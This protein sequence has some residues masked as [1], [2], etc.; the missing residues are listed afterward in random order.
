MG[1]DIYLST[2]FLSV[3]L[4][5]S[6]VYMMF[7]TKDKSNI[8]K[9]IIAILILS[10]SKAFID[11]STSGLENCMTFF[12][13]A[14]FY[15]RFFNEKIKTYES[16][17]FLYLCIIAS[18]M[19]IN[20]LDA[21]LLFLPALCYSLFV[22]FNLKKILIGLVGFLPFIAWEAFSFVYFGFLFPN[23]A[24]SKLNVG[25]GLFSKIK[26]GI[27]YMLSGFTF[28]DYITL[29]III[30]AVILCIIKRDKKQ[31]IA[32]VGVSIYMLY[33]LCIGG[34][35]MSGRFLS[36]PL[37]LSVV[38]IVFSIK[39]LSKKKLIAVCLSIIIIGSIS[40]QS[41][42][43]SNIQYSRINS[44]TTNYALIADER[45]VYYFESGLSW[46]LKRAIKNGYD[47]NIPVSK[48]GDA[49][50]IADKNEIQV[51]HTIGFY[52]YYADNET[53][54]VDPL[55]LADALL[56]RVKPTVIQ[57]PG[58]YVRELPHGY[59]EGLQSRTNKIEDESLHIYY[60]KLK[61]I[62]SGPIF[63]RNRILTA[64]YMNLGKYDYLIEE[65]EERVGIK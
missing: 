4:T 9:V 11:Y 53:Y 41:P 14:L 31:L 16:K 18:L 47:K 65:Y 48:Y 1:K 59:L 15:R 33:I 12:I 6:A 34:D 42:V 10:F 37:F 61:Y 52:G 25:I 30:F 54:I 17:E 8:S 45:K 62:I 57:R 55:A 29:P 40:I 23:T 26:T 64:I 36:A 46:V 49:G 2:M 19:T 20:R 28:G 44:R 43:T 3:A 5:L 32:G 63:D 13:V 7:Y 21:L 60:D 56:A 50:L 38:I 35:F 22:N 24:F 39:T 27:H 51:T 58:H